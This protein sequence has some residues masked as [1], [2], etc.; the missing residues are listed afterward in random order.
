MSENLEKAT[1]AGGCFWCMVH[2]FDE[3]PGIEKVVAGYMGGHVENPTYEQV[4][5]GITGHYEVVQITF[6]PILFPYEK[7]LEQ[8]WMQIDPTDAGGQFYDRGLSYS[9]AIFWHS[10]FQKE[11]AEESKKELA[12]SGKFKKP[13]VTKI[14]P[15]A[16]FYPGEE[17]HQDY[18]KKNPLHYQSYRIGSGRAVFIKEHWG[19]KDGK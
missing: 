19:K 12:L 2:P 6:D 13:I 14:L 5:S 11:K 7:L 3:L 9:T 17:Y 18:Y 1:F 15:A 10:H 16:I 8:Y 4:C